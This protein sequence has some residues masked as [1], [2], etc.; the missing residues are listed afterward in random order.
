MEFYDIILYIS[1]IGSIFTFMFRLKG[2]LGAFAIA[3]PVAWIKLN[4]HLHGYFHHLA[5]LQHSQR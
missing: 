1:S 5:Q 3:M 2:I 4:Q